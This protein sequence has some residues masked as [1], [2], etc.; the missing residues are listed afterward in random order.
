MRDSRLHKWFTCRSFALWQE[1]TCASR[2]DLLSL[3]QISRSLSHT[4]QVSPQLVVVGDT[5][6]RRPQ[7]TIHP[8]PTS[9]SSSGEG[10][11]FSLR[12][13][14]LSISAQVSPTMQCMLRVLRNRIQ[15]QGQVS[16]EGGA[17]LYRLWQ[18]LGCTQHFQITSRFQFLI[19]LF[20]VSP[21]LGE[22][23]KKR[24]AGISGTSESCLALNQSVLYCTVLYCTVLYCTVL[25]CTVLYCT[26]LYCTVLYLE[27]SCMF[28]HKGKGLHQEEDAERVQPKYKRISTFS[29]TQVHTKN[30]QQVSNGLQKLDESAPWV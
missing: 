6:I 14:Q 18:W 5:G 11:T 8:K 21:L 15:L 9:S 2:S 1:F 3:L 10:G 28:L 20:V 13:G 7:Q 17:S 19:Q 24:G 12:C 26:V 27:A 25:Y 16:L 29:T 23:N 30:P 4:V 22:A